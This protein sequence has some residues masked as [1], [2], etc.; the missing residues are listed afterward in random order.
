MTMAPPSKSKITSSAA[1]HIRAFNVAAVAYK[2]QPS[3]RALADVEKILA[4]LSKITDV[5]G[6][7]AVDGI[8]LSGRGEREAH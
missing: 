8:P 6:D 3:E 5:S 2:T 1:D 4:V 7:F